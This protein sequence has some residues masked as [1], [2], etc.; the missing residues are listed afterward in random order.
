VYWDWLARVRWRAPLLV[1][2]EAHHA[3]NDETRLASL[4]RS[5]E[6]QR[7]VEGR[8]SEDRP[9]LWERSW[10]N[11]EWPNR[12]CKSDSDPLEPSVD[13]PAAMGKLWQR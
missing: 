5:E 7:L 6:T 4:L 9:L 10:R 11:T 12:P 2:D 13:G 1:L 3:K 8:A